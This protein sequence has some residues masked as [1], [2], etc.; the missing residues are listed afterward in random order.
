MRLLESSKS[1]P[2]L[3]DKDS[4][5]ELLKRQSHLLIFVEMLELQMCV[6]SRGSSSVCP[7]P[8]K[9]CILFFHSNARVCRDWCTRVRTKILAGAKQLENA[10]LVLRHGY[11]RLLDQ[12]TN[13]R[14]KNLPLESDEK[15]EIM[16]ALVDLYQSCVQIK[17]SDALIGLGQ[18][19]S[20]KTASFTESKN[21]DSFDH[22]VF[23]FINVGSYV[24]QV[25]FSN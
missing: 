24:A 1:E 9:P 18:F 6:A 19:W 8:P 10:G 3:I 4:L 5:I 17:D 14:Q 21:P 23:D 25:I 2:E 16:S 20:Q 7:P 15:R 13:I 12:L 22:C 11:R